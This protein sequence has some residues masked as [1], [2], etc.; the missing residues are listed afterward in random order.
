[1]NQE[2]KKEK[3]RL[4]RMRLPELQARYAEVLGE[5]TRAPNKTFLI[6]RIVAALEEQAAQ[7]HQTETPGQQVHA[8]AETAFSETAIPSG[9]CDGGS[10]RLKDL[11]VEQLQERYQEVVGRATGSSDRR[12]LMWKIRQAQ[13]GLIPVGPIQGRRC[14][15]VERE[16]KVL[17]LRIEAD[18]VAR[19]DEARKR[20]GLK[21]RMELFR[22]ALNLYLAHEGEEEIASLFASDQPA[23]S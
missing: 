7:E 17:P 4:E 18:L 11:T 12:Y 10:G 23:A 14:D 20:L 22:R 6:R 8:I 21:S 2:I 16:Y 19:L 1:M 5:Q 13:K 15:G 9:T 3:E